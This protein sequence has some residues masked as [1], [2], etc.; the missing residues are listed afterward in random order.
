MFAVLALEPAETCLSFQCSSDDFADLTERP[1]IIPAPYLARHSWVALEMENALSR[2]EIEQFLEKS[3]ALAQ[4][5]LPRKSVV[6]LSR[7]R[8]E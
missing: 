1:K 5:K 7:T 3:Y 2:S 8:K 6:T 4:A